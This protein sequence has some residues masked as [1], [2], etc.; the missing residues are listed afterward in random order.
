MRV[1]FL[2]WEDPLEK[3]MAAHFSILAWRSPGQRS[4]V[5]YSPW[6]LKELDTT[7]RPSPYT[8]SPGGTWGDRANEG[9]SLHFPRGF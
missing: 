9:S 5:G 4:L 1:R 2:D 6:G 3:G 7:E 8:H